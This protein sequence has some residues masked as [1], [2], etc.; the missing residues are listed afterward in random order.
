[1][2]GSVDLYQ[3]IPIRLWLI[4]TH[5]TGY[6][7]GGAF[8]FLDHVVV[9]GVITVMLMLSC[10]AALGLFIWRDTPRRGKD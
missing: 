1:M 3:Y 6:G 4:C 7:A 10:F 9:G 8:M 2:C 5:R